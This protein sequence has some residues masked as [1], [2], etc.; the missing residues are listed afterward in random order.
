MKSKL[1]KK[2]NLSHKNHFNYVSK[3]TRIYPLHFKVSLLAPLKK[4][5]ANGQTKKMLIALQTIY[6]KINNL[7][8]ASD[9]LK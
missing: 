9:K 5:S 6:M 8:Y 7:R 3:I 1:K 2:T 4:T